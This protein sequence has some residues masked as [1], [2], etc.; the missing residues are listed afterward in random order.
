LHQHII[1][2]EGGGGEVHQGRREIK[3]ITQNHLI[4]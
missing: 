2:V 1:H 3:E 4:P